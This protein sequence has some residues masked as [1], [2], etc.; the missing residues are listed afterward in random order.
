MILKLVLCQINRELFG[1][2]CFILM[3]DHVQNKSILLIA[4][5]YI[6]MCMCFGYLYP[7]SVGVVQTTSNL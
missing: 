3:I 7:I 5:K 2:A 1:C 6:H 4:A